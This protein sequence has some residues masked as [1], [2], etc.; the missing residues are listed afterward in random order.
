MSNL[1]TF[2]LT[3]IILIYN[4]NFSKS[5]SDLDVNTLE[6]FKV[7]HFFSIRTDL[8]HMLMNTIE[9]VRFKIHILIEALLKA[10][11]QPE[12]I[13]RFFNSKVEFLPIFVYVITCLQI[14]TSRKLSSVKYT[15]VIWIL[16]SLLLLTNTDQYMR[17]FV[18]PNL[19]NRMLEANNTFRPIETVNLNY[20]SILIPLIQLV[21][22]INMLERMV[23]FCRARR[24]K[25][26][27]KQ[28][29]NGNMENSLRKLTDLKLRDDCN[30]QSHK[31][32][33]TS[34]NVEF[35]YETLKSSHS[36]SLRRFLYSIIC[37]EQKDNQINR[38]NNNYQAYRVENSSSATKKT[39]SVIRPP[40]LDLT[41][42]VPHDDWDNTSRIVP[43][44][45]LRSFFALRYHISIVP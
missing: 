15:I 20:V 35:D 10:D 40:K 16:D 32:N 28:E 27:A 25:I 6:E 8:R 21:M 5:S 26:E 17:Y 31:S 44:M 12:Q 3:S 36:Y 13:F 14:I 34:C 41:K 11:L 2:I 43:G 18:N 45:C 7:C 38:L 37:P 1:I 29:L 39:H 30:Y 42:Y 24:T 9:V 19:D 4:G 22:A 23:L 33:K